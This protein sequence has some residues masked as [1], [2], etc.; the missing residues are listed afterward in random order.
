MTDGLRRLAELQTLHARARL[1][2]RRAR[3]RH[4]RRPAPA[5]STPAP[6]TTGSSSR[7]P[8]APTGV[9][10]EAGDDC[11]GRQRDPASPAR[12]NGLGGALDPRRRQRQRL[13]PHHLWNASRRRRPAAP[14]HRARSI[15]VDDS[16]TGGPQ[17]SNV[18]VV[19]GTGGSDTF[20]L[21]TRPRSPGLSD[22]DRRTGFFYDAEQVTYDRGINGGVIVNGLNGDD[23]FALD[24]T[25]TTLSRQRRQR[26]RQVPDRPAVHRGGPGGRPGESAFPPA[27]SSDHP[28]L[29]VASGV[30]APAT[31]NGG[32]GDD[33]FDGLPQRGGAPA[34]RR[35]RRR[36][37]HRPHLRPGV[38]E[39]TRCRHRRRPRPRAVR[40]ATHRSRIDGGTGYDT[41]VVVGTEFGDT[42][43]G[44]RRRHLRRRPLRLLRQRRAAA[45]RGDGGRRPGSTSSRPARRSRR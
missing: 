39:D 32:T 31:I 42:L 41:V 38:A 35:L 26:Q 28:R 21:R 45:D 19:N 44:H 27:T 24:D 17:D 20:L 5:P 36:H 14:A 4:A 30:I 29:P 10:G 7:P 8:A 12:P 23:A 3:R 13:L 18:L 22:R 15:D 25:S 6:A 40:H 33:I 37:V 2:R 11:P 1:R 34:Q 16:L 9:N 43:R